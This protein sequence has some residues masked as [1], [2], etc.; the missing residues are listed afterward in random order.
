MECIPDV[1]I[2]LQWVESTSYV[3][4]I[5][6]ML[7]FIE[8]VELYVRTSLSTWCQCAIREISNGWRTIKEC[9]MSDRTCIRSSLISH[10]LIHLREQTRV[11]QSKSSELMSKVGITCETL[12]ALVRS[13]TCLLHIW[14]RSIELG[15]ITTTTKAYLIVLMVSR[16]EEKILPIGPTI[17]W[18]VISIVSYDWFSSVVINLILNE[19]S[20]ISLWFALFIYGIVLQT[21]WENSTTSVTIQHWTIIDS[22]V[23]ETPVTTEVNMRLTLLT[24]LC[25]NNDYTISSTRTI[26]RSCSSILDDGD[27]LNIITIQSG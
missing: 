26:Q 5:T 7:V 16:L 20:C 8:R 19:C 22:H 27:W 23:R 9:I 14:Q 10:L 11:N 12:Q 13:D 18:F 15:V 25:C 17:D 24:A 2:E 4:L 21:T 3:V 6:W 1:P